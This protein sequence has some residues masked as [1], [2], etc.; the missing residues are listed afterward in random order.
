MPSGRSRTAAGPGVGG[1]WPTTRLAGVNARRR[2]AAVVLAL[3]VPVLSSCT[4]NFGEQTDQPYNPSAGVDDRTGEVDVL[5]ALVVSGAKGS[6]TVIAT[7]VNNNQ[8]KSDS[9]RGVSGA[10]SD[11]SVKVT[12]GGKTTIPPGGLLNLANDG[13][14]FVRGARVVPGN[15]VSLT[16]TFQRARAITVDVPVLNANSSTIYS[17]VTLPPGT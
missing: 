17:G 5:N 10:G 8:T 7:L 2:L 12:P 14:V 9:L 16:F 4:V 1:P 6:G 15:F 11:S 13:R 3:A